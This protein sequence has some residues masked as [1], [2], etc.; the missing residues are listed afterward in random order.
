MYNLILLLVLVLCGR[1]N[2]DDHPVQARLLSDVDAVVPGQSFRLGSR[3][4][5]GG[6]MAHVLDF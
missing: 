6:E 1:L 5:D 4:D 2:A 3:T